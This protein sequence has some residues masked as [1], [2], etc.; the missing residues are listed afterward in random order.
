MLCHVPFDIVR[1]VGHHTFLTSQSPELELS[2]IKFVINSPSSSPGFYVLEVERGKTTLGNCEFQCSSSGII[3]KNGAE[4][5][6]QN[7]K[8]LGALVSSRN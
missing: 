2:N 4:L 5:V 3:V 6:M 7:C 8:V 1:S